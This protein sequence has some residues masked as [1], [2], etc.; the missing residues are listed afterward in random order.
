M[1][2]PWLL[3][4]TWPEITSRFGAQLHPGW[5][6]CFVL[7]YLW[8][9]CLESALPARR[10]RTRNWGVI[11][12]LVLGF[13]L[14]LPTASWGQSYEA[15]KSQATALLAQHEVDQA[16]KVKVAWDERD[17]A[18][19][20]G[21]VWM[22]AAQAGKDDRQRFEAY[23][24][25]G[26]AYGISSALKKS[27]AEAYRSARD[28]VSIPKADRARVGL[29]LA[30]LTRAKE[31]YLFVV[32]IAEATPQNR[33]VAFRELG[34]MTGLAAKNDPKLYEQA[35]EYAIAQA[36]ELA[37]FEPK[38]VDS[39]LGMAMVQA[40]R[41]PDQKKAVALLERLHQRRL[42]ILPS[43]SK[44]LGLAMQEL[45][46]ANRLMEVK[47]E[48][49]ALAVWKRVGADGTL[50]TD[51]REEA[52]LKAA[53]LYKGRKQLEPA[54]AAL[55]E[56]SKH[57]SDNFVFSEKIARQRIELYDLA[58]RPQDSLAVL[59]KLI[60][61]PKIAFHQK[62]KLV[63][64]QARRL[65][66]LGKAQ[67]AES[68]LKALEASDDADDGTA[69]LVCKERVQFA[70]KGKDLALA[71]KLADASKLRLAVAGGHKEVSDEMLL[72]SGELYGMEKKYLQ[73]HSEYQKVSV[74][75]DGLYRPNG[76]VV[77][78]VMCNVR[79]AI[80]DRQLEPAKQMLEDISSRWVMH[81]IVKE[82]LNARYAAATQQTAVAQTC[83]ANARQRLAG[84]ATAERTMMQKEIDE[85]AATLPK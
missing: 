14:L 61:H 40:T 9:N 52:W 37:K 48:D 15:L 23:E 44:S 63:P 65:F 82:I 81:P 64:E 33:A 41:I 69:L 59:T 28:I 71:R 53:E 24:S 36:D 76:R 54:L 84:L 26:K 39:E 12:G 22:K 45:G 78:F 67:E 73:A 4:R 58:K 8:V 25:A 60:G 30:K 2:Y 74:G 85:V 57:R 46:L 19:Q 31:D 18:A 11:S 29:A 83:L 7:I 80:K 72:L 6:R 75:Y 13:L 79:D 20:A 66:A 17:K 49:Q 56:A 70:L 16:N 50:P 68:A 43:E 47:A 21:D 5:P 35:V 10:C 3:L 1:R 32:G 77:V 27:D 42:A 34:S 51:K 38:R 62:E 55:N